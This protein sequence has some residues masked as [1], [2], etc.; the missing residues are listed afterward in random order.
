MQLSHLAAEFEPKSM[1]TQMLI[2]GAIE[3]LAREKGKDPDA[4]EVDREVLFELYKL[5]NSSRELVDSVM[6]DG[7]P[8]VFLGGPNPQQEAANLI[9]GKLRAA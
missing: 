6:A 3:H 4:I 7:A 9:Q 5:V 1:L 2:Q 8:L